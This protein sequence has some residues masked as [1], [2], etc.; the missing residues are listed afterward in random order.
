MLFYGGQ[1]LYPRFSVTIF[2][3]AGKIWMFL[4]N[5]SDDASKIIPNQFIHFY[6]MTNLYNF[7]CNIA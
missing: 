2:T 7:G 4:H 3:N 6:L 5:L 1:V